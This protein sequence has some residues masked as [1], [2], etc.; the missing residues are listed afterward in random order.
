[1][2]EMRTLKLDQY[3]LMCRLIEAGSGGERPNGMSAKQVLHTMID[4]ETREV[5]TR[6]ADAAML[7]LVE[8][9]G[10]ELTPSESSGETLH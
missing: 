8:R 2:P 4:D 9:V 7:Y 6:L 1:M 3:E 5:Y 10:L